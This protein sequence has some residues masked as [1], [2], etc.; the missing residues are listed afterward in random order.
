MTVL[1]LDDHTIIRRGI[2]NLLTMRYPGI[3]ITDKASIRDAEAVL[4]SERP[5]LFIL[6]LLVSDGNAFDK[7]EEWRST[8]PGTSILIYSM[9]S[10]A[11]YARR[12]I[13]LGCSG[14]LTKDSSEEELIK[15]IDRIRNGG[16]YLNPEFEQRFKN[17]KKSELL[18]NPFERLSDR[19][20]RVMQD[21]VAD[22]SI[23]EIAMRM[24]ISPS[25]VATY[26]SRLFDKLSI[27]SLMELRRLSEVHRLS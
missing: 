8:Y 1:V 21:L 19:E 9:T 23:K 24:K 18:S 4:H 13:A 20:V 5:D 2:R 25:T 3:R 6:D 17:G 10:E 26:K 14:F 11:I 22:L 7:L 15:A 27:N 16:I 12:V